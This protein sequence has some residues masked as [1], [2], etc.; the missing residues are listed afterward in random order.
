[1][2]SWPWVRRIQRLYLGRILARL[3]DGAEVSP[4]VVFE[5]PGRVSVG[6]N[7]FINRGVII[8]A[9]ADVTIGDDVMI[10]PYSVINSGNHVYEDSSIPIRE[11]GHRSS[12]IVIEPDVWIGAHATILEGC[13]IERGA[14]IAAGS[15]V[16]RSVAPYT[17]VGG[18][19]ASKLKKRGH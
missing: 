16:V 18:I 14:V 6:N 1:M 11:Q 2:P 10:G 17:V 4:G 8:T 5:F 3:G 12:S 9:R 13:V 19:P 15:V 7:V